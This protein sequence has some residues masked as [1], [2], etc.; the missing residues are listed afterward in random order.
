MAPFTI[1]RD[2]TESGG[3]AEK[4]KSPAKLCLVGVIGTT[5]QKGIWGIGGA[6]YT[7][8]VP[9]I[10]KN[11]FN[12]FSCS[13][14]PKETS[15]TFT[16][17]ALKLMASAS[18]DVTTQIYTHSKSALQ[19]IQKQRQQSGQ[20]LPSQ[21]YYTL[22]LLEDN[23]CI[24]KFFWIPSWESF[25]GTKSAIKSAAKKGTIIRLNNFKQDIAWKTTLLRK[26]TSR[27]F[28]II[29]LSWQIYAEH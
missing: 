4:S 20:D 25:L 6:I 1:S 7:S 21:I 22:Q 19:F 17:Y 23:G 12:S 14:S 9:N 2:S 18:R 11:S 28:S 27:K 3:G 26:A 15:S 5:C 24:V 8:F 13:G 16:T 10:T 29:S